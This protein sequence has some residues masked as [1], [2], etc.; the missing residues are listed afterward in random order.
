MEQIDSVLRDPAV[1][2]LAFWDFAIG[3]FPHALARSFM[4]SPDD[5]WHPGSRLVGTDEPDLLVHVQPLW[6]YRPAPDPALIGGVNW[7]LDLRAAL[8]RASTLRR[9]GHLDP[10]FASLSG[11]ARELG[12]RLVRRGGI[13]RQYP[14]LVPPAV[15]LAEGPPIEDRY[16]LLRSYFSQNWAT[17]TLARRL[18]TGAALRGEV[19]A[20]RRVAT[21]RPSV[22]PPVGALTREVSRASVP[23][24][25]RVSIVLPTYG[26]YRYVAEVLDDI[27]RQTIRPTQILIADGNPVSE[28]K[29][30]VYAQFS[31]LPIEVLWHETPGIC[32]GRNACLQRV[33]GDY[34]WFVDDDSRFESD[35]LEAHLRVLAA[36][37]ADVSVGPAYTRSRPELHADQLEISCTHMDCGTTLVRRE[38]FDRVGGFD[39]QFNEYLAGEDGEIGIRFQRS[40]GLIVNNPLAKRFHYVAPVGGSRSSKA[41]VHRFSRWSLVPRPVQSIYYTAKRYFEPVAAHDAMLIAGLLYGWRRREGVPATRAWRVKT[42]VGEIIAAP[43]TALRLA[44]SVHLGRQMV[45][46]G[47]RIEALRAPR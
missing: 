34:V 26:R 8:L 47:P 1:D 11:A 2:V 25:P 16:R 15:T 4:G 6:Q 23:T 17:Y 7:R 27:R 9:L 42:L 32:S 43:V 22:R 41:S 46:Q 18:M 3:P 45:E 33:T 12:Y 10:S 14:D 39:M 30:E 40:G 20:W 31:D 29:P 38:L 44:R 35:N 19:E 5:A 28:R 24:N 21:H 13:V 37:G 36:Y